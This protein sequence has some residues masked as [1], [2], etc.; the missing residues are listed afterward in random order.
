MAELTAV[1]IG[2]VLTAHAV[3]SAFICGGGAYNQHLM[4]RI[5]AHC[6]ANIQSST[7]LGIEPQYME[8]LLFAWLAQQRLNG[9]PVSLPT[10]HH[11]LLGAVYRPC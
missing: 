2:E 6:Q 3:Q 9:K 4:K 10:Q 1:C 7:Q 8:G 5:Q 11:A